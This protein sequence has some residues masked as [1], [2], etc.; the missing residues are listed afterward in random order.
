MSKANPRD[1]AQALFEISKVLP[2]A[3]R[4]VACDTAIKMMESAG[5][6]DLQGFPGRVLR[7]LE[8]HDGILFASIGLAKG[9]LGADREK[10]TK[11]LEKA[12]KR[13]V[14]LEEYIDPSLIG[15]LVLRVGDEFFDA[16]VRGRIKSLTERLL[17][18]L[19]T[20]ALPSS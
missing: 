4:E 20:A 15:G 8:A 7:A 10:F 17:Q 9:P 12:F 3:D 14:Q 13:R 18:P 11:A 19:E 6:H 16:S 2:P 5:V 1:I